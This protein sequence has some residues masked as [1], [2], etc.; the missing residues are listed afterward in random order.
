[1][2]VTY[3]SLLAVLLATSV[4]SALPPD[5]PKT[6]EVKAGEVAYLTVKPAKDTKVSYAGGFD[7]NK[8][9]FVQIVT[10]Q[11]DQ[12]DFLVLPNSQLPDGDYY[13]TFWTVGEAAYSQTVV[14][15]TGGKKQE[16]DKK[17]IDPAPEP[18]PKPE[19]KPDPTPVTSDIY[20]IVVEENSQRTPGQAAVLNDTPEWVKLP[21]LGWKIYDKDQPACKEK[22]YD[23]MAANAK[24]SSG[25]PIALPVMLAVGVKDG[26]GY[27][28]RAEPLRPTMPGVRGFVKE[29]TGK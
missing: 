20:L 28:V 4:A 18:K 22:G 10:P 17:K 9:T 11:P 2:R 8:L 27:L 15:V 23:Q 26:V 19:P 16:E 7:R 21:V 14:K 12:M 6:L 29:V 24:D 5:V 25:N 3:G 13:V 1:M